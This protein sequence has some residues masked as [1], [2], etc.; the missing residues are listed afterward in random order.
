MIA[1]LWLYFSSIDQVGDVS[2]R[3]YEANLLQFALVDLSSPLAY[4]NCRRSLFEDNW[5][6]DD[7]ISLFRMHPYLSLFLGLDRFVSVHWLFLWIF[8]GFLNNELAV[9]PTGR[10]SD[11]DGLSNLE[12]CDTLAATWAYTLLQGL[13]GLMT[14]YGCSK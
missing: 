3:Q 10:E 1:E 5:Q 8:Q 12:A 14:G 4:S 9:L 2:T 6:G 11:A 7:N 13:L